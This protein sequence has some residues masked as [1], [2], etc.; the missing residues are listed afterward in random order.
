VIEKGSIQLANI[1]WVQW[2]SPSPHHTRYDDKILTNGV[3][4]HEILRKGNTK[5]EEEE[6]EEEKGLGKTMQN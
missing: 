2:Q 5:E 4:T 1:C 3:W 6:E